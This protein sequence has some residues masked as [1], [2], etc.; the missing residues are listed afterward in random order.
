MT[1][2]LENAEKEFAR[3]RFREQQLVDTIRDLD[4]EAVARAIETM[5]ARGAPAIGAAA[6]YGLALAEMRGADLE[7]AASRLRRT[8]PT[9]QDLFAAI[10]RV[11]RAVAEGGSAREAA[12]VFA[13]EEE[14]R[15]RAIGRH[16]KPLIK[17]GAR[18]LTHCN[19]GALATVDVG[20]VMAPLRAAREAG[21]E[22]FVYVSETR[23][24]LQGSPLPALE[25]RQEGVEHPIRGDAAPG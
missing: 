8:R 10:D 1:D 21:R 13:R 11:M 25:R 18:I 5:A 15:C 2:G 19:A 6:A 17:D 3:W 12:E 23:P 22:F 20:T 16:G 9:G 7:R 24:R 14:E 4:E